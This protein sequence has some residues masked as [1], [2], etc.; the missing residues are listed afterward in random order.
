[1]VPHIVCDGDLHRKHVPMSSI[2][3]VIFILLPFIVY[4]MSLLYHQGLTFANPKGVLSR[5]S[6][7]YECDLRHISYP[8]VIHRRGAE[9][10][11]S[12][13]EGSLPL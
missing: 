7:G 4:L 13:G 11:G 2:S 3:L 9:K 5:L 8:Q 1:M 12:E 6:D 10:N